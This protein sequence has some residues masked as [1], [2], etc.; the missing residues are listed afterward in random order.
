M[1]Y[2]TSGQFAFADSQLNLDTKTTWLG[3]TPK[4]TLL[5]VG[6]ELR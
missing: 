1:I 4:T 6:Q 3:L 2:Y 5:D